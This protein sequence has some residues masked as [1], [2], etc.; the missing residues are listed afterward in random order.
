MTWR[1]AYLAEAAD[2]EREWRVKRRQRAIDG[3]MPAEAVDF[4]IGAWSVIAALFRAGTAATELGFAD[5]ARVTAEGLALRERALEA[6]AEDLPADRRAQ[7]RLR[8]DC[9]W[10]IHERIAWHCDLIEDLNRRLRARVGR[11]PAPVAAAA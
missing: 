10:A 4:D 2:R 1:S 3:G 6:A 5:L 7:L 11:P 9:L 8:R